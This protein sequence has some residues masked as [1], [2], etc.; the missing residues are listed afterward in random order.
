MDQVINVADYYLCFMVRATM[1][2]ILVIN[3][4]KLNW[5]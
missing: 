5:K 1:Y 2:N 3:S 4:S